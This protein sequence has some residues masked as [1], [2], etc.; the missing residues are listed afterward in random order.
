MGDRARATIKVKVEILNADERLFP[1]MSG[2]VY[3]LP[4]TSDPQTSTDLRRIF[5]TAQAVQMDGDQAY[6]WTI[7]REDRAHRNDVRAGDQK[8]GRVEILEGL[9]GTE[10][11]I[12][13]TAALTENQIVKVAQ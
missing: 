1:D 6:V 13:S 9:T 11:V 4:D 2:T 10:R 5:C 7:D 8:D 3:F 12:I